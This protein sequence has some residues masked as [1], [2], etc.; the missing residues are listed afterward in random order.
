MINVDGRTG[1]A[2][3]F[4]HVSGA[5]QKIDLTG[6]TEPGEAVLR[7]NR[8]DWENMVPA[9]VTSGAFKVDHMKGDKL[10]TNYV[11]TPNVT[12]ASLKNQSNVRG[13]RGVRC[14]NSIVV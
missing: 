10:E 9:N 5:D 2:S 13:T 6:V 11:I 14:I 8:A 1:V 12:D 7:R 3:A 4:H